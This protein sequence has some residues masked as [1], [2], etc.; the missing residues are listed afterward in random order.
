MVLEVL[1]SAALMVFFG[2]CIFDAASKLPPD[3]PGEL[4]A[5]QWSIGILILIIILL[6]VNIIK[7]IKKTPKEERTFAASFKDFSLKNILTSK[8]LWGIVILVA[9]VA[10]VDVLGFLVTSFLFCAGFCMLLGEKKIWRAL[11]FSLIAVIALYF[12]FFKGMGIILPRGVGFMR[13]FSRTVEKFVRG[14]F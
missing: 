7:V 6:A 10:L 1:F 5:K 4:S 12:I 3:I 2:Y 8:L 14:L 11:V 9:Y 13:T